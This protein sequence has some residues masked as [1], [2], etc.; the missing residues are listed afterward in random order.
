MPS[1]TAI[2]GF[3]SVATLSLTTFPA[4]ANRATNQ[5][6]SQDVYI[7]GDNNEVNQTINQYILNNPGKGSVQR[8]EPTNH[9]VRGYE[10]DR[11]PSNNNYRSEDNKS[12]WGQMRGGGRGHKK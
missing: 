10:R 12:D 11:V 7:N 5:M 3:V 1:K 6:G 4:L 8:R 2:F 9:S